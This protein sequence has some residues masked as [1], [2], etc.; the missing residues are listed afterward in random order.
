MKVDFIC[1]WL[2]ENFDPPCSYTINGV[3]VCDTMYGVDG[4]YD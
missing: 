4:G 2:A 3:D 1:K